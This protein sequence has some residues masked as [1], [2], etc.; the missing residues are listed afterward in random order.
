MIA[1]L[2]TID[3]CTIAE[4]MR[5]CDRA[6]VLAVSPIQDLRRWAKTI[7]ALPGIG[8]MVLADDGVP[9]A[10]GGGVVCGHIA[11]VWFVATDRIAEPPVRVDVHRMAL[12]AHRRLAA[13]GVRRCTA[14]P[15][16]SN[17]VAGRW[18]ARMGYQLEGVNRGHGRS[19]ENYCTWGKLMEVSHGH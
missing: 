5:A 2:D 13:V 14:M 6:E 19:G 12:E 1:E 11:G 16:Q 8:L 7:A 9:V 10:M 15:A 17:A 3:A 4:R 18:L